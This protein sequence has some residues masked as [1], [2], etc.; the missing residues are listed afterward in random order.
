MTN[1]NESTKTKEWINFK[2][3]KRLDMLKARTKRCV[4]KYCGGKLKLRRIILVSMKMPVLKFSVGTAT[5]LSLVW[6]RRFIKAP[7][8]LWKAADLTVIRI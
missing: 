1:E 6:N 3:Q 7:N 5:A 2:S 4:C 8:I